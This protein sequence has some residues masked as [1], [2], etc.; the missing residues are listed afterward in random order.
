MS[1]SELNQAVI[2]ARG[3]GTRMRKAD[4]SAAL[5]PEQEAMAQTGLKAMINVGRPFLDYVLSA[6][7][8]AGYVR[9]CLVI[10]PE[11]DAVREYYRGLKPR[12]IRVEFAVQEKPLGTADAVRSAEAFA[13]GHHIAVM[14]SDNYYPPRALSAL[15]E[16]PGAGLAGFD[17][18][19]M[20]TGGNIPPERVSRFAVVKL[21]SQLRMIRI[22]EKPDEATLA[23]LPEPL[24]LSMNCW[25][26]GPKIFVAC[27]KIPLSPRGEYEITDAVQYAID[28]LG[29]TFHMAPVAAPVLDLSSRAD[30]AAVAQC[31]RGMT[32]S[33]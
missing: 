17:R 29:E 1:E 28:H 26:F 27:R 14:N 21:D 7:A 15:R 5:T 33:L 23:S 16:L 6:L 24:Y 12:R 10:G 8:D 3:L 4:Q 32:V 22:L 31:V 18:K 19:S 20:L 11:H 30:I 13:G 25:R 9:V 2:L